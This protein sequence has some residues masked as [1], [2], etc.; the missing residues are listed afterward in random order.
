[1]GGEFKMEAP[2]EGGISHVAG[3]VALDDNL[4][5]DRKKRR[6]TQLSDGSIT[7]RAYHVKRP[8]VSSEYQSKM[9]AIDGHNFRRQSGKGVR[10]LEK[11]WVSNDSKDRIFINV[12]GWVIVN[13]FL[14]HQYFI[15]GGTSKKTATEFQSDVAPALIHNHYLRDAMEPGE[16]HVDDEGQANDPA[17]CVIN[18]HRKSN[19][20]KVCHNRRTLYMCRKCSKP[21]AARVRRD[22]GRAGGLKYQHDGFM[23]FCKGTCFA[24]HKCGHVPQRRKKGSV[25]VE[26]DL[27]TTPE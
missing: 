17:D 20:C 9:G 2:K 13:M 25:L 3:A 7:E 12:V 18:P 19:W 5:S 24:R 21:K 1:M 14:A 10:P 4:G 27:E 6:Y 23:H 16:V 22:K 8:K 26:S 15:V 11:V